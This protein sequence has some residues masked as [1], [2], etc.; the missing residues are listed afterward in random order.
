VGLLVVLLL[1]EALAISVTFD[2][3][4]RVN[5]PGWAGAV[6]HW[7]PRLLRWGLVVGGAAAILGVWFHRSEFREAV[8]TPYPARS[9]AA[10][11][12]AHLGA[13]AL[14]VWFTS[15]VLTP[16]ALD[17][18]LT[19][20]ELLAWIGFGVL[21]AGFWALAV[22]PAHAWGRLLFRGRWVLV[23]AAAI[24][25]VASLAASASREGW[26]VLSGPTLW[27]SNALLRQL[28]P[29]V[30]FDPDARLLGTP[31]FIVEVGV[32]CSGYEGMGLITAYLIGY[33]VLFR[34]EL[35][36]PHALFL[37]PLGLTAIWA[38]NIVRIA[39]L[40]LIGDWVSPTL[41]I[42]GFHSQAGWLGF[43][44]VALTLVYSAHRSRVFVREPVRH[45]P[46]PSPTTTYLLP[47][48]AAVAVQMV[49]VAFSP[50]PTLVYPL[51]ALTVGALLWYFWPRYTALRTTPVS[52][53]PATDTLRGV[54][55]GLAVFLVWIAIVPPTAPADDSADP[56]RHLGGLPGWAVA[57]WF[58]AKIVGFVVLTPL[59]EEL[60]FRGYLM[61]RLIAR[62]FEAV[63][64]GRLTVASFVVSS[65]LFGLLHGQWL[66]GTLAGMGYALVVYRTGRLRDAVVAH[67]VTNGLLLALMAA[68]GNWQE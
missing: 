44:L 23:G 49:S 11:V 58:L 42:G 50:N 1:I 51:R 5:D 18:P 60:A 64:V 47:L 2:A 59:V 36:F 28:T 21:T 43:N 46:G 65:L 37:I 8:R 24:G 48:L 7:S 45:E 52:P 40:I 12:L 19:G 20:T 22:L 68:T 16:A 6:V 61:R 25:V 38:A 54:A 33:V 26:D 63:P 30:V 34:R 15:R 17:V 3:A 55:M 13:Y 62:D 27:A 39:V 9:V 29:E 35:R 31:G 66:A 67:A 32:P 56:A 57:G 41:A 4:A 14:F 53:S 10:W